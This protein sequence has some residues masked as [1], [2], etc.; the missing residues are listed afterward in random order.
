L[1]GVQLD[2][3]K[4]VHAVGKP[5]VAVLMNGRPLSVTWLDE[6]VP[7]IVEAWFLGVQ[8]GPAVTDVLFGDYNPSGKLTVSF[9]RTVGQVP[10]Y[11]N[12]KNTGRPPSEANRYTSKY[13]DVPWTPLYPF[14]YGLSYT[15]FNYGEPR[16]SSYIIG[17]SDSLRVSVSVTNAGQRAGEEVVQV[18]VRDD[19]AS[20]TRPV[21]ELRSFQKILLQPGQSRELSFTLRPDDLAFWN[22]EMKWVVEPGTFT[23]FVGGNSRD[24][25]QTTF[26][27]R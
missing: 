9:P 5:V 10:I 26:T 4:R 25:K 12:H 19:Y 20:V 6:N 16:V 7:A 15:T 18:Y 21:K 22:Q 1:P 3:V 13:L 8:M 2:L 17:T 23:V 11:Y 27:V 24:T 14:G